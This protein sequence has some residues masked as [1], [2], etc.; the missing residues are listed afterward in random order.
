[1]MFH[2]WSA[3][4]GALLLFASWPLLY[5]TGLEAFIP[6]AAT[7]VGLSRLEQVIFIVRGGV[8]LDAPHMFAS[9]DP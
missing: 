9:V 4:L 5:L 6:L 8:D 3:K 2:F 7:I 1:M